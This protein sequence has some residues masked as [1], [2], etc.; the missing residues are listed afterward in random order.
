VCFFQ[1]AQGSTIVQTAK[2]LGI[3]DGTVTTHL[4]RLFAKTGTRR[5]AE[6]VK[7]A[8]SLTL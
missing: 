8:A 2:E 7:P 1:I 6:L 3:A 4:L 5:Q